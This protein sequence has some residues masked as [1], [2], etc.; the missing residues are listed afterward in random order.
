MGDSWMFGGTILICLGI[1]VFTIGNV[2]VYQQYKSVQR[3]LK[4]RSDTGGR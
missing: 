2:L 4:R 1:A 3:N